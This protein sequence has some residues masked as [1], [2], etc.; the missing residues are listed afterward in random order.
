VTKVGPLFGLGCRE[1]VRDLI[2]F[3]S[4]FVDFLFVGPRV[5]VPRR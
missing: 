4:G 2:P 3:F 5:R 1:S